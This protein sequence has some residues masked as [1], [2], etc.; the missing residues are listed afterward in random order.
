[1]KS[2]AEVGNLSNQRV[3]ALVRQLVAD[4]VLTRE[5]IKRKAYFK[6]A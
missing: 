3:S 4:G 2:V 1:M 5:E 6:L